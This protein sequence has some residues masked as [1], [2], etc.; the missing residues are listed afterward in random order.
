MTGICGKDGEKWVNGENLIFF[1]LI[2]RAGRC[3]ARIDFSMS[4]LYTL[5][6]MRRGF[7][8]PSL[9]GYGL[10]LSVRRPLTADGYGLRMR[11]CGGRI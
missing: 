4:A 1:R 8:P 10:A 5:D 11:R 6:E 2:T 9:A 7:S 3:F